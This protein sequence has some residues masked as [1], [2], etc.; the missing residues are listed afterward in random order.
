MRVSGP[1]RA[2]AAAGDWAGAAV[3]LGAT[4]MRTYETYARLRDA[5]RL[6][7]AGQVAEAAAQRDLAPAFYCGV[8]ATAYVRRAEALLAATA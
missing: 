5:E 6:A 7:Q 1:I 3:E 4:G 8:G 2:G